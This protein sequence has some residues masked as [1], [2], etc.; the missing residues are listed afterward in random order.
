[1]LNWLQQALVGR[2][3]QVG[4]SFGCADQA[5]DAGFVDVLGLSYPSIFTPDQI[6]QPQKADM[7]KVE[8]ADDIG[9]PNFAKLVFIHH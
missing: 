1:M 2:S 6:F 8:T 5:L 4:L 3:V 7:I 9:T